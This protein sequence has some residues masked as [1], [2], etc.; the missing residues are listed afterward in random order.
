VY[1]VVINVIFNI[2][3]GS[4]MSHRHI[5]FKFL[6]CLFELFGENYVRIFTTGQIFL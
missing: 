4:I 3:Y 5:L 1:S 2:C 6:N